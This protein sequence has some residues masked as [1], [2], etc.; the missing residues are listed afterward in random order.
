MKPL[1]FLGLALCH[2]EALGH[3][4]CRAP[5]FRAQT[6]GRSLSEAWSP[7]NSSPPL[8][9]SLDPVQFVHSLFTTYLLR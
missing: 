3:P 6:R 2:L 7:G 5:F 9:I 8:A 1:S 4:L